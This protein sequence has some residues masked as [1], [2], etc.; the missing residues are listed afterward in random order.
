MSDHTLATPWHR[1]GAGL[2]ARIPGVAAMLVLLAALFSAAAPGLA[3]AGDL[4]N[5]L[6]QSV[7]LLLLALPMTLIILTE[8]LDLSMGAVLTFASVVLATATGANGSVMLA[9]LG[10]IAVGAAFGAVNGAL[11]AIAGIP[12][13]VAT[14]G[15]LGIA[16]GLANV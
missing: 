4:S 3:T 8:G 11:V 7:I 9:L 6:L 2:F 16:Q 10:G 13:F 15:S 14:L 1:R 5:I 12:P